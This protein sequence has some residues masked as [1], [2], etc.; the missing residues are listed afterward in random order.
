VTAALGQLP[1]LGGSAPPPAPTPQDTLTV[2]I[3]AAAVGPGNA[4]VTR[5]AVVQIGSSLPQGYAV[6]AWG[7][8][9]D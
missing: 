3:I 4:H 6:L 2:R 7:P 1:Q 8:A 9:V 5:A